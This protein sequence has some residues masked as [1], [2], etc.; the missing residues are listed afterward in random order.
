MEAQF[1]IPSHNEEMIEKYTTEYFQKLKRYI[2]LELGAVGN[3]YPINKELSIDLISN[4]GTLSEQ[5]EYQN[6]PLIT[7]SKEFTFA[8]SHALPFHKGKC[9]FLHGHE[10]RLK[11]YIIGPVNDEG[12][13]MDFSDLK[14]IVKNSV[15]SILDHS[16]VNALL[17]NPT[18]ENMLV[19]IWN[20]LQYEGGLKNIKKLILWETPTSEAILTSKQ[21]SKVCDK[22]WDWSVQ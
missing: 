9:R 18:A 7:I 2:A 20:V 13:V 14:S 17:Y 3:T 12:M 4:L 22:M 11:V 19:Y 8:A 6:N 5:Q 10:W 1:I 15:L 21:M 16:F